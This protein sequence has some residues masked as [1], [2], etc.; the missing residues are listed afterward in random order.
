MRKKKKAVS[1]EPADGTLLRRISDAV[2]PDKDPLSGAYASIFLAG[3]PDDVTDADAA[4]LIRAEMVRQMGGEVGADTIMLD[5][6]AFLWVKHGRA[7][8]AGEIEVSERIMK[9]VLQLADR[10]K[11]TRV[12]R[13]GKNSTVREEGKLG[14]EDVMA[15]FREAQE[16]HSKDEAVT[17][18]FEPVRALPVA[19]PTPENPPITRGAESVLRR[20]ERLDEVESEYRES[21]KSEN[22]E[23]MSDNTIAAKDETH[24][25]T[26]L[27]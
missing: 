19:T 25:N 23:K 21:R 26:D 20:I 3:D 2:L 4:R 13:E 22:A 14:P 24:E 12:A 6:L 11:A 7:V 15:R 10:L 27:F 16:R 1:N 17:R 18:V 8:H 5:S 9:Q